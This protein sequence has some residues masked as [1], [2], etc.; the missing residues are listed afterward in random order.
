MF[1]PNPGGSDW[2]P[3]SQFRKERQHNV[4]APCHNSPASGI[5][6]KLQK[7]LPSSAVKP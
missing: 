2:K 1:I 4:S 5:K 6:L 7:G 3:A